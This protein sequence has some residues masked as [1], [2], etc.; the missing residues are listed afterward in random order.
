MLWNVIY[1]TT[2]LGT[3]V[4]FTL[5]VRSFVGW[6]RCFYLEPRKPPQK[7]LKL[8]SVSANSSE[9]ARRRKE[10]RRSPFFRLACKTRLCRHPKC[11]RKYTP[12]KTLLTHEKINVKT[13]CFKK[14]AEK[15]AQ[16][17]FSCQKVRKILKKKIRETFRNFFQ[18]CEFYS[19]FFIYFDFMLE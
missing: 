6:R 15:L 16:I 18:H 5:R 17:E 1:G 9:N 4:R 14:I 11:H 2:T 19:C 7:Q 10:S 3:E 13:Q 12:K 8:L